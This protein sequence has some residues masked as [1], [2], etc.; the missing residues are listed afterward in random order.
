[1]DFEFALGK[2]ERDHNRIRKEYREKNSLSQRIKKEAEVRRRQLEAKKLK[3]EQKKRKL[4][5]VKDYM[6]RCE[7][8]VGTQ[9][10]KETYIL[11][12]REF[13]GNGDKIILPPSVLESFVSENSFSSSSP[14]TFRVAVP[15]AAY[16]FPAS[17]EL[18]QMRDNFDP[19][20]DFEEESD[21]TIPFLSE[22]S[23]RYLSYTHASVL[24]FTAEEG[25]VGLPPC[26]M[27]RLSTSSLSC[28]ELT[29]VKLCKGTA[30]TLQPTRK[31]I[32]NGFYNLRD[33]KLVLEQS[34]VRT[35]ATLTVKDTIQTWHRK[36]K[37]FA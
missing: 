37:F 20:E 26:L 13:E 27:K 21:S 7:K 4:D 10:E 6:Q 25:E 28:L 8:M 30:C 36:F 16:S 2:L 18:R 17:E 5:C 14:L 19:D 34:I 9:S 29:R 22:L 23:H 1:M 35:R 11:K 3:D 31:A 32:Q 24:E 12:V 15:D 33:V